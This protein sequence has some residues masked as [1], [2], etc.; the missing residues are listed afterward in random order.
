MRS[1]RDGKTRS[2]RDH[3]AA[4]V[5]TWRRTRGEEGGE[6]ERGKLRGA[7]GKV[8][9]LIGA[10]CR[11][12]NCVRASLCFSREKHGHLDG[13]ARHGDTHQMERDNIYSIHGILMV[14]DGQFGNLELFRDRNC[15]ELRLRRK[16]TETSAQ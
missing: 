12:G 1:F 5:T 7:D 11:L 3:A 16:I 8:M 6:G 15:T 2:G 14:E 13:S 4:V 9:S 10:R